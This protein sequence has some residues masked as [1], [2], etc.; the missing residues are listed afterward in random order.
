MMPLRILQQPKKTA[1]L[2]NTAFIGAFIVPRVTIILIRV[3]RPETLFAFILHFFK[4]VLF[5]LQIQLLGVGCW[6]L[7]DLLVFGFLEGVALAQLLEFNKAFL[8][9]VFIEDFD[10][11]GQFLLK[12]IREV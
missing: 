3:H 5:M 4:F 12:Q 1:A 6:N 8:L 10:G 7:L 2:L 11:A 9:S